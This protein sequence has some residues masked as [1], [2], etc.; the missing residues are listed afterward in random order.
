MSSHILQWSVESMIENESV[1]SGYVKIATENGH[2]NSRFSHEKWWFSSSLCDSLP[3]REIY[4]NL[5][6][7][8]IIAPATAHHLLSHPL[9]WSAF[10]PL[11]PE[12]YLAMGILPWEF[13]GNSIRLPEGWDGLRLRPWHPGPSET[14]V[15]PIPG[16]L[17]DS[18]SSCPARPGWG[19]AGSPG[20]I[21]GWPGKTLDIGNPRE[22][23]K[24]QK[25][26]IQKSCVYII[27]T[28]NYLY[29][30]I[31]VLLIYW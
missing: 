18:D 15:P 13:H 10:A 28:Y 8:G 24:H 3:C 1:P 25:Y 12:L 19:Y 27:C 2:W 4:G 21:S 11:K 30:Y 16:N 31:Y 26:I 23:V 7:S 20:E 29:V 14:V 9:V 6:A 22:N 5:W 17:D